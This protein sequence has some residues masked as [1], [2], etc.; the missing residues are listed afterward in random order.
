M[1]WKETLNTYR[2][3]VF[4]EGWGDKKEIDIPVVQ[5]LTFKVSTILPYFKTWNILSYSFHQ[6]ALIIIGKCGFGFSFNWFTPPK[7]HDGIMPVQQALQIVSETHMIALFLPKWI[8]NLPIKRYIKLI[9][10]YST[11]LTH[12]IS[13]SPCSQVARIERGPRAAHGVHAFPSRRT[14]S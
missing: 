13:F 7:S 6:L 4:A 8:K 5:K 3:M 2:E 10:H 14:Q 11:T 12:A 1:V 9:P